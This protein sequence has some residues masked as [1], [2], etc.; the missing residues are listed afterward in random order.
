MSSSQ[1]SPGMPPKDPIDKMTG[2]KRPHARFASGTLAG[3][4]FFSASSPPISH[5]PFAPEPPA[6]GDALM[7]PV[8]IGFVLLSSSREPLPS[9]RI[10]VLNMIPFLRQARFEPH[11]V[12]E[13]ESGTE[14][15]ELSG[16]ARRL[17]D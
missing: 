16:L 6:L 12:Y 9:T 13:P 5:E 1:A 15:P 2:H 7:T 17:A 14:Q 4:L 8:K 3:R 10:A 11:I